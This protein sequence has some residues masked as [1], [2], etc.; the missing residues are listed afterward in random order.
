MN[1]IVWWI[2]EFAARLSRQLDCHV[3]LNA[4]PTLNIS[5]LLWGL[6]RNHSALAAAPVP[7][8]GIKE[9]TRLVTEAANRDEY[10]SHHNRAG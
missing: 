2:V 7:R 5:F 1:Y 10:R 9:A 6:Q 3:S 8:L 4:C